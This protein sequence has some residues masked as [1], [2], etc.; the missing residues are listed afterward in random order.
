[1]SAPDLDLA[2]VRASLVPAV[3]EDDRRRRRRSALSRVAGVIATAAIAIAVSQ[4][5]STGPV[6]SGY[7]DSTLASA[8]PA[9][10][11]AW[12]AGDAGSWLCG[13]LQTKGC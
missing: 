5:G 6:D 12:Q 1:V 9:A 10:F 11:S 13:P 8:T 3:Y 4:Q 2:A 7:A